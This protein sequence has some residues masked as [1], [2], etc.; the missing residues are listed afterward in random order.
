MS[1]SFLFI[2]GIFFFS[3]VIA[4]HTVKYV[5]SSLEGSKLKSKNLYNKMKQLFE[6][7]FFWNNNS[8]VQI[9][10]ELSVLTFNFFFNLS[11]DC[12]RRMSVV[13]IRVFRVKRQ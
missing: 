13:V 10:S 5:M 3:A 7:K 1:V 11:K 2:E 12:N 6:F 4:E 8:K 9:K